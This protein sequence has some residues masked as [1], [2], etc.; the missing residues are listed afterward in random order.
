MSNLFNRALANRYTRATFRNLSR[1]AA[2]PRGIDT[3]AALR[4]LRRNVR[5]TAPGATAATQQQIAQQ[6]LDTWRA[7]QHGAPVTQWSN[8]HDKS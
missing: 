3:T 4:L 2:T 8:R 1:H 6:L 7:M 5:D